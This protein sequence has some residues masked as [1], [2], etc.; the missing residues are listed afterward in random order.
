[1]TPKQRRSLLMA[2][3]VA[4]LVGIGLI[5]GGLYFAA[6][7]VEL[8]TVGERVNGTVVGLEPG[9]DTSSSGRTALFPIVAFETGQGEAITFRHRTGSYPAAYREGE[10]VPV[11][12]LPDSP[13]N[14]L[15]AERFRNW[16]LPLVLLISGGLLAVLT[17]YG[18]IRMYRCHPRT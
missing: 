12:Y 14:A 17:G 16:L 1:M 7:Q 5:A 9:S 15:I 11:I 10:Q 3:P 4:F 13:E 18:L 6:F 2:L 8:L